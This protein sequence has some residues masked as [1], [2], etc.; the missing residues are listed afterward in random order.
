MVAGLLSVEGR[1]HIALSSFDITF[2]VTEICLSDIDCTDIPSGEA[3][4]DD[5]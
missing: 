3:L 1:H 4:S 2:V 5:I